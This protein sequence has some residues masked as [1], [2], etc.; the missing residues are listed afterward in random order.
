MIEL[1]Q[2]KKYSLLNPKQEPP[3]IGKGI[4]SY[5]GLHLDSTFTFTFTKLTFPYK[6][7]I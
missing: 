6:E 4:F 2:P 7:N 1:H 5:N 3:E